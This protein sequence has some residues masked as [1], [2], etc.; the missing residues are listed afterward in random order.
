MPTCCSV[1]G[2]DNIIAFSG[3]AEELD[4]LLEQANLIPLLRPREHRDYTDQPVY[5][6]S[7]SHAMVCDQGLEHQLLNFFS[8][9]EYEAL[10]NM[11]D[12]ASAE[13]LVQQMCTEGSG[14]QCALIRVTFSTQ[15]DI[16]TMDEYRYDPLYT[17]EACQENTA[18]LLTRTVWRQER[19][20]ESRETVVE[21]ECQRL[22][23]AP[24]DEVSTG[25]LLQD[26]WN[27]PSPEVLPELLEED[28]RWWKEL[29]RY[30]VTP[31]T[32]G[33]VLECWGDPTDQTVAF[34]ETVGG[35]CDESTD[36]ANRDNV[37][38]PDDLMGV[39]LNDH[40]DCDQCLDGIDNNCN[41]FIDGE[42]PTCARCFIGQGIGCSRRI[43]PN[44]TGGCTSYGSHGERVDQTAAMLM[45]LIFGGAVAR[46]RRRAS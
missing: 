36:L 14:G 42:D 21:W 25:M 26:N 29:G 30:D 12:E 46:R 31:I 35:D 45:G 11:N 15:A 44:R 32:Q 3:D 16:D 33:T 43:D 9:E 27:R 41:G 2:E 8:E 4:L 37:E 13:H 20:L 34:S 40:G 7:G 17:D 10:M 19:I 18:Q 5:N 38:G 23:G 39:F 6:G 1:S 24:C 22:Y 28:V